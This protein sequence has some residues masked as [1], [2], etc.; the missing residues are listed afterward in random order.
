M[1]G[2]S[3]MDMITVEVQEPATAP[4]GVFSAS[5]RIGFDPDGVERE[6]SFAGSEDDEDEEE[7]EDD[8]DDDEGEDESEGEGQ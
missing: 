7:D 5:G 8:E 6:Y 1:Y 3:G 2:R 4:T